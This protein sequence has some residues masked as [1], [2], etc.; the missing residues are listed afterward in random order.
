MNYAIPSAYFLL[1]QE[2]FHLMLLVSSEFLIPL[3]EKI[4]V[5]CE[6]FHIF[7]LNTITLAFMDVK[8]PTSL[9][10]KGLSFF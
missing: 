10:I 7:N 5:N 9:I 4:I 1:P 3:C 2:D 6:S 8:L